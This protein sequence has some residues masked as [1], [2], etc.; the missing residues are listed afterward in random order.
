ML[1]GLSEAQ[2]RLRQERY[3]ADARMK[4]PFDGSGSEYTPDYEPLFNPGDFRR[5]GENRKLMEEWTKN[6]RKLRQEMEDEYKDSKKDVEKSLRGHSGPENLKNSRPEKTR[7]N[8]M[9]QFHGFFFL[10]IFSISSESIILFFYGIY[11]KKNS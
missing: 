11:S 9:N 7:E 2:E 4:D 1:S 3:A 10:Y 5:Q 6:L 8:E